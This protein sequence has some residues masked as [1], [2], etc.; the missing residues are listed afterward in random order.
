MD[1]KQKAVD[2]ARESDDTEEIQPPIGKFI[3]D[4]LPLEKRKFLADGL[5]IHY[6]DVCTLLKKYKLLTEY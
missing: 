3:L 6:S 4:N 1:N 2:K 5:Y